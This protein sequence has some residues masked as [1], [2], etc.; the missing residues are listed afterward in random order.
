MTQAHQGNTKN[1]ISLLY[2]IGVLLTILG[3]S[4][5]GDWSTFPTQPI[6]FIY[7]FHMPLFFCISGYLFA[8]SK[9]LEKTGYFKWLCN[10]SKRLLIP[11]FVISAVS[12][13]P[14]T[15][16][17]VGNLN[18]IN[19]IEIFKM[20]F[21][22]RLNI[23]GHFWFLPVIFILYFAFGLWKIFLYNK[24]KCQKSLVIATF[25]VTLILHFLKTDITW[26]GISDLCQFAIYFV[27]GI[28][29]FGIL[30]ARKAD[31]KK[32]IVYILSLITVSVVLFL[33]FSQNTFV[34]FIESLLMLGACLFVA[35]HLSKKHFK[36]VDF[37]NENVFTFYICSWPFQAIGE[38][39][40]DFFT[41]EWY[42]YTIVM[43]IIGLLSPC[44]VVIF[45]KKLKFMNFKFLSYILGFRTVE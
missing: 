7:S 21:A 29:S 30:E 28:A 13:V 40:L 6:E 42:V 20:F 24:L 23:W 31:N 3:H 44:A 11:Y 25:L 38:K 43:F 17:E 39:M 15:L 45:Y 26:L 12:F 18:N 5:S 9:S 41:V 37:I 8:K 10:K 34:M 33:E 35:Q 27:V 2:T 14:K 22:P 4:H 32:L 36:I 19:A 16:L 1:E